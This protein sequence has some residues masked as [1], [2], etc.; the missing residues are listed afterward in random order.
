M[1]LSILN[2]RIQGNAQIL[3]DKIFSRKGVISGYPLSYL[4]IRYLSETK[5]IDYIKKIMGD[6]NQIL[7]LGN[8]IIE[9]MIR[10]YDEKIT[11]REY[12]FIDN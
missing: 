11:K 1:K 6:N 9:K 7:E 4:A 2:E 12:N 10:Y 3:D 5:G 8:S